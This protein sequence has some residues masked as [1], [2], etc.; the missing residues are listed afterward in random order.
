M[1]GPDFY[2]AE[3]RRRRLHPLLPVLGGT[4]AIAAV[5]YLLARLALAVTSG[6]LP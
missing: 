5:L 4:L 3:H 1:N 6:E 2:A